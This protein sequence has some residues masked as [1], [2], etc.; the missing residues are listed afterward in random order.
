MKN[1]LLLICSLL[2]ISIIANSAIWVANNNPGAA[3]GTNVF[4]GST[5]LQDAL[6]NATLANGDIIYVVPSVTSYGT[7]TITKEVTIFGIGI[8]PLK[9]IAN[10][11]LLGLVNINASNVRLSGLILDNDLQLGLTLPSATTLINITVENCRFP[12][13][14]MS[15][16]NGVAVGNVLFRNNVITGLGTVARNF[17]LYTNSGVLITN[18]IIL[19]GNSGTASMRITGAE[20]RYNVFVSGSNRNLDATLI[21]NLFDHNIFY[22]INV[23]LLAGSTGNNWTN[24]LSFGA[25][26]MTFSTANGNTVSGNVENS[27]PLFTSVPLTD[28]WNDSF[29]FTLLTGSPALTVNNGTANDIG[30]SGGLTPFDAEGNLLPLI[31]SVTIPAMIPVGTDLDV[32]IKAKGN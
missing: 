5:A 7:I 14:E 1:K 9:D 18:N 29:D 3:T 24:N 23:N 2:C 6:S 27:D 12:R 22:G 25:T 26:N 32:T 8:R 17:I 31:E 30:A 16:S 4:T 21:N 19:T 10:R 15:S 11:S 28:T 20:I 13:V